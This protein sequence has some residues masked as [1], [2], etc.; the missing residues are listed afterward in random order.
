MTK[1]ISACGVILAGGRATRMGGKDKGL[2]LLNGKPLWNCVYEKLYPQVEQVVISANR[3]FAEYAKSGLKVVADSLPDYPGPL[4]GMLSVMQQLEHEWF[5]FCPCDT[6]A[7]PNSL[8]ATLWR[9]RNKA[10]AVWVHDGN[11]DHPAIVLMHRRLAPALHQ[12]LA[13]DERR[14]M[15]F[16]RKAGGHAVTFQDSAICF[17]NINTPD[18]LQCRE[19]RCYAPLLAIAAWSGTGKTT[20]LKQLIPLLQQAGV[21]AGLIKHTHHYMDVDT[22]G[23]DSYELR[24][25]GAHQTLV[26]SDKRWALMTETPD[27]PTL[28]LH[29]LSQRMDHRFLDLILVEGFKQETIPKILLYRAA[30]RYDSRDLPID[31]YTIAIASDTYFESP[32]PLLDLNA[33]AEIARFI[34]S[35]LEKQLKVP[36]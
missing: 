12:Y 3:N 23:K 4:A 16:L 22:P 15:D 28:N 26:A 5:L 29:Y 36:S 6:P 32:V 21:R 24:H 18:D 20:L 34:L 9:E 17:I 2:L 30:H 10:P 25:A 14:V 33:P 19:K 11:K 8:A 27:I 7:I 31:Q 1:Q 35:W 13:A